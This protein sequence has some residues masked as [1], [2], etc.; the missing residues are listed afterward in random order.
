[1]AKC[2]DGYASDLFCPQCGLS[3]WFLYQ[4]KN[5]K[6]DMVLSTLDIFFFE[7]CVEKYTQAFS[8]SGLSVFQVPGIWH[9]CNHASPINIRGQYWR[10][11]LTVDER[12]KPAMAEMRKEQRRSNVL[13]IVL[14]SLNPK[15]SPFD[16]KTF[17]VL[18]FHTWVLWEKSCLQSLMKCQNKTFGEEVLQFA[19]QMT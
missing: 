7:E 5:C 19:H 16:V 9:E 2:D 17:F 18:E 15:K 13:E 3:C 8:A 14:K 1:M 6:Y 10:M 11:Q 12:T 4:T